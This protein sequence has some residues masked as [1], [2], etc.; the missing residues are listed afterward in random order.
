MDVEAIRA[1]VPAL[2]NFVWFQ[3]GFVSL[4]PTPIAAEHAR[5]M[6]ELY[7]HGPMHLLHPDVELPRRVA[8]VR[9]IA[10]FLSI[11][12]EEVA[13]K[14]AVSDGFHTVVNCL[15][16]R[17]GDR[18]IITEEEPA[19]L[20]G[21]SLHLA[22]NR[23][24]EVVK[25]PLVD[26]IEG[27]VRAVTGLITDRTRLIAISHVVT[28]T[29]F[30]LPVAQICRIARK[31]RVLT[32]LDMAHSVGLYPIDLHQIECDFAGV[33]NYKWTYAPYS[34]GILYVRKGSLGELQQAASPNR[35][36]T[37]KDPVD[38]VLEVP[39]SA[40]RLQSG[41]WSWPLVHT[42]AFALDWLTQIGLE[43]I[44]ERTVALTGRL[45]TALLTIP[46]LTLITPESPNLSAA[47]VTFCLTGWHSDDLVA[48]LKQ[49]WNIQ[50]KSVPITW[51]TVGKRNGVPVHAVRASLAFFLLEEEVDLLVGALRTLAA[52]RA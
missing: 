50:I 11:K 7:E 13:L 39:D 2:S 6:R 36:I 38:D 34:C 9:R 27:Q 41:P 37:I 23:G 48:Q 20:L 8:S 33:A 10:E 12:T 4:T 31:R 29:G 26:D 14:L 16:W 42:W 25:A 52:E 5:L 47:L 44:W 19:A 18:I 17:E 40:M 22:Q 30:R 35:G 24:V 46:G 1:Q 51:S 3:N 21:T 43:A 15:D 49:R 32:F 28:E 45:K